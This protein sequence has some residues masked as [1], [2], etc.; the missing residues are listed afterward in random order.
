MR[1]KPLNFLKK[2]TSK[3]N[4]YINYLNNSKFMFGLAMIIV[5][6]GAKYVE[7]KFTKV[8]EKYFRYTIGRELLIFSL[9]FMA[10]HDIIISVIMTASFMILANYVFNENSRFTVL[11]KKYKELSNAMD[12]DGDGVVSEEEIENAIKLLTKVKKK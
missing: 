5:N 9:V 11:P 4:N 8:Q 3:L 12:T 6:I 10:T 1:I 7:V 2:R